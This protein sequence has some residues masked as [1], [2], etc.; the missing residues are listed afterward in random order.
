MTV[1]TFIPYI[2][3]RNSFWFNRLKYYELEEY[4]QFIDFTGDHISD[5]KLFKDINQ[6]ITYILKEFINFDD[7]YFYMINPNINL[8]ELISNQLN[9]SN[10][11]LIWVYM[12]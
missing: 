1:S 5:Y 4:L 2:L 12:N 6:R 10:M 8:N 3:S 11:R 7:P 9:I